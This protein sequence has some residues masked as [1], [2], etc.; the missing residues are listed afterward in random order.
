MNI[1]VKLHSHLT[2]KEVQIAEKMLE[3]HGHCSKDVCKWIDEDRV[4]YDMNDHGI[5]TLMF[6]GDIL[7]PWIGFFIKM[8]ISEIEKHMGS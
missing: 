3:L 2:V 4:A 6:L 7:C 1:P 8:H 5:I